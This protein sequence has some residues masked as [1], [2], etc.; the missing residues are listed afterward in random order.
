ME[1]NIAVV[2]IVTSGRS[3]GATAA[4]VD[5]VAV[6]NR[7]GI[8]RVLLVLLQLLPM[9]LSLPSLLMLGV[10]VVASPA[11]LVLALSPSPTVGADVVGAVA[12]V[13]GAGVS[14]AAVGDAG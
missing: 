14:V 11:L 1:C 3:V 8:G 4:V 2:A 10:R 9:V 12:V 6:N 5:T 7:C 13:V